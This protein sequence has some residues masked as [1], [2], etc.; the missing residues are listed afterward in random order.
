MSDEPRE[1]GSMEELAKLF[2]QASPSD[3]LTTMYADRPY[4]GQSHTDTG[5]RGRF[6]VKGLTFRDLRDCY[7]RACFLSSGLPAEQYPRSLYDL[8]WDK[9]D[10]L[11]VWLNMACEIERRMGIF[12][13]LP[14]E[15]VEHRNP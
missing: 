11:A 6:E 3:L 15:L 10:P 5:W 14:P 8:P 2:E 13:N 9:M 7:V 4:D 12:P 1:I